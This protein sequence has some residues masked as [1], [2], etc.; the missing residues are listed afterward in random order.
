MHAED[1][2]IDHDGQREEVEHVRE[3]VP[4]VGVAVL[5]VAFGVEAVGLGYASGLVVAAD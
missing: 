1:L 3:V 4:D 5:A 2:V